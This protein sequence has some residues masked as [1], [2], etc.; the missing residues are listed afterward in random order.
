VRW[1][2]RH[3]D[4][5]FRNGERLLCVLCVL[6]VLAVPHGSPAAPE[7][8]V[9]QKHSRK[10]GVVHA[11]TCIVHC[12]CRANAQWLCCLLLTQVS[13]CACPCTQSHFSPPGKFPRTPPMHVIHTVGRI[14]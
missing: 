11:Q 12:M 3:E 8:H 9:M 13:R 10:G 14:P 1:Y 4:V 6:C 5:K 7:L 2:L